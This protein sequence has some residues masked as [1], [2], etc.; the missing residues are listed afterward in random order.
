MPADVRLSELAEAVEGEVIGSGSVLIH[1]VTHDSRLAAP[2]ALFVA[3]RGFTFDGHLFL[4]QAV[5]A[6][7]NGHELG[8][9][10][11]EPGVS[12]F[13]GMGSRLG[14]GPPHRVEGELGKKDASKMIE[15]K[16]LL[17][18]NLGE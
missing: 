10:L 2:G 3:V 15:S 11:E 18:S 13:C 5:A 1:D 12:G 7:D 4:P 9:L 14:S 17:I 6:W 16:E 8:G